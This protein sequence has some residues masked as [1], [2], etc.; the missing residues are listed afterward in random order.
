[1]VG[2]RIAS[3]WLGAGLLCAP[4]HGQAPPVAGDARPAGQGQAAVTKA[5][6]PARLLELPAAYGPLKSAFLAAPRSPGRAVLLIGAMGADP[7]QYDHLTRPL[8]QKGYAVLTV[9]YP[10]NIR[11]AGP[12]AGRIDVR[13]L[14]AD[15]VPDLLRDLDAAV[16]FLDK[17]EG[18]DASKIAII[19]SGLGATLATL[20]GAK[21]P[22]VAA[23]VYV[24]PGKHCESSNHQ[25]S[26]R[27]CSGKPSLLVAGAEKDFRTFFRE[28]G[29]ANYQMIEAMLPGEELPADRL[30]MQPRVVTELISWFLANYP[31]A[32]S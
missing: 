24:D 18:V 13:R 1:M 9:Q 31:P 15:G 30:T 11:R 29:L 12:D 8:Q 26:L 3:L 2:S 21:D 14:T 17:E 27:A 32:S 7:G 25:E 5:V 6:P 10:A 19:G 16:A 20:M 23:L 4:A 22:R 28:S